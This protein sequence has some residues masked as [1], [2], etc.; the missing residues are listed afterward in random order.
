MTEIIVASI[1]SGL[2]LIGTVLT[3]FFGNRKSRQ[4]TKTQ[5]TE[6]QTKIMSQLE[7]H[8]KIQDERIRELSDRVEKHNKVVERTYQL[9]GR[10]QCLSKR[11]TDLAARQ[12]HIDRNE[13]V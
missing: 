4:D 2:T 1:T 7:T 9:E 5:L 3:V 13:D 11:V 6:Q 8:N 12:N 10:V